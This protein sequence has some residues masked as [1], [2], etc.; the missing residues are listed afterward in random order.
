MATW[1]RRWWSR[2]DKEREAIAA[3]LE[4]QAETIDRLKRTL[5]IVAIKSTPEVRGW[6]ETTLW[7]KEE[8]EEVKE[9]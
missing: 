2:E 7:P 3:Q 1:V 5:L 8:D 6:I 9:A 4:K